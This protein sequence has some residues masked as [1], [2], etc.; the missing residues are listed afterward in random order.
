MVLDRSVH[1]GA[2]HFPCKFPHKMALVTPPCA[3]RLRRFTLGLHR[4]FCLLWSHF[5]CKF[6]CQVALV[7]CHC[8]ASTASS[9]SQ[10]ALPG[11]NCEL[12]IS[13][14]TAGPQPQAPNLSGRCPQ[15]RAPDL[16]AGP[17]PRALDLSGRCWTS[18]AH[19]RTSTAS[20]RS[21]W[22]LPHLDSKLHI[23]VGAAGP[24]LR[25][26]HLSGHCQT[27]TASSTSQRAL[28]G[29]N[30]APDLRGHFRTST[31]SSGSQWALPDLN[32]E[33]QISVGTSSA[34]VRE[35]VRIDARHIARKNV[36]KNVRNN[37]RIDAR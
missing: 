34:Y 10:W 15:L 11:L 33:C 37:V 14:G 32:R 4:A 23:S 8:Q 18:T 24:Q 13:M 28:P 26:P 2:R 16:S 36:R 3:F 30:R 9:E 25:A 12:R 35:N 22:A 6:P 27:S 19:C 5:A 20:S 7:K 29:L 17:Q 1:S 31:A 21:Q